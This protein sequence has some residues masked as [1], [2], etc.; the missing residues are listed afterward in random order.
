[1]LYRACPWLLFHVRSRCPPN[2]GRVICFVSWMWAVTVTNEL[3]RLGRSRWHVHNAS[4][5]GTPAAHPQHY[6]AS[7]E[8][9]RGVSSTVWCKRVSRLSQWSHSKWVAGGCGPWLHSGFRVSCQPEIPG[10]F[11]VSFRLESRIKL[12]AVFA[13]GGLALNVPALGT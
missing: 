7:R 4:T 11:R 2:E 12:I 5:S 8:P 9:R 6:L 1:M 10:L 3:A 13:G